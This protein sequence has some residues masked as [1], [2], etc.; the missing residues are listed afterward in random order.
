M[1]INNRLYPAICCVGYN[2]PESMRR[3]L[4]S[5][6]R[7]VYCVNNIPLII[8][9]D[10]SSL[11]NEVERV[12]KEFEWNFGEKIIRRF[13]SR[14]GLRKH[15]LLCGD[16]SVKYGAVIFLEDDVVVAP[17][18]YEFTLQSLDFYRGSPKVFGISLYNQKWVSEMRCEFNPAYQGNDVYFIRRD[19][20]RGQCWIGEQWNKFKTWFEAHEN[21]L[22]ESCSEIPISILKWPDKTSWSKYMSFYLVEQDLYYVVP[23]FS[24]STNMSEIGSHTYIRSDICQVQL[25]EYRETIYKFVHYDKAI[26]YDSFFERKDRFIEKIKDIP[27]SEICMD[28]NGLKYD[29]SNYNYVLTTKEL[30]GKNLCSYGIHMEPIEANIIY[31]VHGEDIFLYKVAKMTKTMAPYSMRRGRLEHVLSKYTSIDLSRIITIKI[32]NRIFTILGLKK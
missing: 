29:F 6:G 30:G 21:N 15:S 8:S 31:D 9:I 7:G 25:S 17:G 28:L 10:E 11:S 12:A 32:R 23:Y 5:I 1:D 4:H 16:L 19:I 27:I 18:F 20:S 2:R 3:L 14:L 26:I 22:P 13:S 24:F